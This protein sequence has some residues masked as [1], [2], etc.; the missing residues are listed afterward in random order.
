MGS[1]SKASSFLIK[2]ILG[3]IAVLIAEFFLPG[4]HI[5]SW[6]TGFLLAA[7]LILINITIKPLMII[8][9]FP[10]TIVTLGLFLLVINALAVMIADY[11]IPGFVVDGF[12]WALL[13]AVVLSIINSLFGNSLNSDN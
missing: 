2:I 1:E 7:V 9:T 3:G 13:F 5:D 6:I 12:W 8:L 10:L 4:I 11:F